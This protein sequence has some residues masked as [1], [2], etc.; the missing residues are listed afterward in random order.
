MAAMIVAGTTFATGE[1]WA[2]AAAD[3][4]RRKA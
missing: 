3:N 4:R 1:S 2:A